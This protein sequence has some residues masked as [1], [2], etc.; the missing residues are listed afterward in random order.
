MTRPDT[1]SHFEQNGKK[2]F[3]LRVRLNQQKLTSDLKSRYDFIVCGAGASGCVV[4]AKLAADSNTHVLLLEAGG[5]DENDLVMNPNSWPMTLGTELDW[6]FVAQPNPNLNGRAIGYSMGKVLGGGSSINV[7]TWSRGHRADWDFYAS[8][9]DDPSW[10]YAAVLDLY[11][12]RIEAWAGSPDPDYRGT[13]GTVHVQPAADPHPFS[14]ALLEGAESLGL[15]RFPNS[16]G[17]MMEGVGGCAF[18]DEIVRD[19][20]RQSIFRSYVYPIMDQPN[21]T[22]LTDALVARILFNR[23][24]A[25]GVEFQYQGKNL[26]VEATR[27][28]ILSLGAIHTP[29]LLMQSGIGDEAEL[30]RASI[31]VR[32]VLPGV[33]RNVHDH[34]AFGCVWENSGKPSPRIPRSQTSCFW[35]TRAALEA[36]NFYVYSH[37]GPD[38]S[39]EN[40]ARFQPPASCWSLSGGMRPNSR[41]TIH[42]TGSDPSDPV[43]I[44]TNYLGDSQDLDD[45]ITGL[46]LA[47]EIGNSSAL[48]PFTAREVAPGPLSVAELEQFFRNG[49]GTHWHQSGTAK[50]GRDE[51]SVVDSKLKVYGVDGLRIADASILPRV[52]TGNTMA[53]CVVIGEFAA[54]ALRNDH[55]LKEDWAATSRD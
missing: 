1:D 2:D 23:D 32:N 11:R 8:E 39:P 9:S 50:M 46:S 52:T 16:N 33:G 4:A 44:D 20:K 30:K 43:C 12:R 22:A 38:F 36:P 17:R 18:I 41:G 45:L 53:P 24:R 42:L 15:E 6:G 37:G 28:V 7:S 13:H 29:K 51:M 3:A 19:G 14:V 48:Q 31:P 10:S 35:K 49:L 54:A 34:V 47:R 26:R 21:I 55:K 5:T 40:A 27:E 25:T